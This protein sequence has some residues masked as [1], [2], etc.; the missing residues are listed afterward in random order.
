VLLIGPAET[1]KTFAWLTRLHILAFKYANASLVILRKTLTSTFSTVLKTFQEKVIRDAPV[2]AFG[3]EKPQW[4]DYPGGGRIWVAGLDKASRILSAEHD[5]IYVNQAEELT[6]DEWETLTTRTTGRAGH[7]PYNQTIGDAN[8]T[9]PQHWM[10]QREGITRFYSWHQDNPTLYDHKAKEW[11]PQG[12]ETLKRLGRLTGMRRERLFVGRPV[13][14]EGVVYKD[15]DSDLHLIN[16]FQPPAEWRKFRVVDFGYTNPFVCQW[17]AMDGDGRMYLYRE[18]YHTQ[19]L[20]EDHARDIVRLSGEENIE[21]TVC[22]HDAEDRA[23]LERYGIPTLPADKAVTVGVQAVEARLKKAGDG[24]PRL[25]LMRD[26]LV[27]Q[28]TDL[29]VNHL[30]LC[31]AD[32]FPA[33]VWQKVPEGKAEKEEPLK[34]H[35]HGMDGT[36]YGT[37]YAD[38][39][40]GSWV[41]LI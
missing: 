28:D 11:R 16:W 26:S 33:Y 35:D 17:W 1:G 25:F 7:M 38:S 37:M 8:P 32:E 19:R 36:R 27:K 34:V 24:R 15:Y 31:T 14:A 21:V 4:F 41:T 13:Q 9:Y 39:Y 18:I 22:D 2:I 20:V 5:I 12:D 10:Y 29:E 23:T 40:G 30:P 6:L 3:G